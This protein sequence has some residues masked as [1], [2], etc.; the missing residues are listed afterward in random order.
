MPKIK[1][2]NSI[3]Q[4]AG[5]A[6]NTLPLSSASVGHLY[7]AAADVKGNKAHAAVCCNAS[8]AYCYPL[9]YSSPGPEKYAILNLSSYV[10]HSTMHIHSFF[11][12]ICVFT[13]YSFP[14]YMFSIP[15][16]MTPLDLLN[17]GYTTEIG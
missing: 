17:S 2:G 9:Q 11:A 3:C 13:I 8:L 7:K 4:T 10:F 15:L 5:D 6:L 1:D 12:K 16:Y 14:L